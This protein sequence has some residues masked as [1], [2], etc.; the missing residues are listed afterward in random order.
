MEVLVVRRESEL[1]VLLDEQPTIVSIKKTK[2]VRDI[3]L[4]LCSVPLTYEKVTNTGDKIKKSVK[5][6]VQFVLLSRFGAFSP[7][8]I[9]R[10]KFGWRIEESPALN[11]HN[12]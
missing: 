4:P 12:V 10:R 5:D 3:G 1:T 6:R 2:T 7:M 9:D 8:T 11:L